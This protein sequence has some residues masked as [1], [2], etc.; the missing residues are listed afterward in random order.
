MTDVD[1]IQAR[2]DALE[3]HVTYQ[4][5]II[6]ELDEVSTQQWADIADLKDRL[7]RLSE[8]FQDIEA[9]LDGNSGEEQPPPHY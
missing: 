5:Q 8:K 6:E 2:L 9:G 1:K 7:Q 3:A 4:D